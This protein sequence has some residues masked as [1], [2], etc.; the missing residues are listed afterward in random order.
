MTVRT[1]N[2]PAHFLLQSGDRL[3]RDEFERRYH[4]MPEV[5]KAELL[6]GEVHMASPVSFQYHGQHE[7]ALATLFGVYVSQTDGVFGSPNTTVRLDLDNEPQP[8]Q[9]LFLEP[10]HG[11]QV[12]ID[13]DGYITGAPELVVEVSG[14]TVSIDLGKK[15]D[16]YRRNG[17]KEYVVWRVFDEAI[18]WFCLRNGNFELLVPLGD[19]IAHFYRDNDDPAK[20]WKWNA[21]DLEDRKLWDDYQGAYETMLRKTSSAH[22]P[23]RVVPADRKWQRNAIIST[24]VRGALEEMNP[25]YPV[26]DWKPAD[27]P[28]P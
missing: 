26:Y 1:M 24:I 4:A 8:D 12:E 9:I 3:S 19:R 23:W 21:A 28:I 16:V 17:V 14:S 18:D 13:G 7:F 22:A 20:R 2:M 27:F 6:E 15:L 5:K 10:S 25:Q 11:G